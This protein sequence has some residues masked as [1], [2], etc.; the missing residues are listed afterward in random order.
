GVLSGSAFLGPAAAEHPVAGTMGSDPAELL[1]VDM[2]Q[3]AW[4]GALVA[5]NRLFGLEAAE[6][7]EAD[8][9]Q[10]RGDRR[11]RHL[12]DLGDLGSGQPQPA[13]GGDRLDALGR[14]GVVD[15]PW[16][17]AAVEQACLALG[18]VA[19]DPLAGGPRAHSGGLGRLRE[20][21]P[22]LEY[23]QDHP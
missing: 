22:L 11:G 4:A 1:H 20:R 10:D 3:L 23:A 5:A 2:D 16:S 15:T 9:L 14:G 13:Q 6:P 12:G 7:A 21:D 8:P 19:G 18:A 17:R